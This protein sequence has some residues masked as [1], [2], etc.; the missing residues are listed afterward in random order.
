MR[1]GHARAS[2]A[3]S[4]DGKVSGNASVNYLAH[5]LLA[6]D[7]PTA[8]VGQILADCVSASSIATFEAEIQAGIRAHQKI[9]VYSDT[10][11]VFGA[12][13]QRLQPPYRRFA[14]VLLDVYFDHFLAK[15]WSRHGDGTALAEFAEQRYEILRRYRDLP[16]RRFRLV[17]DAMIRDNWLV[18]YSRL[19]GVERALRGISR[20]FKRENPIASGTTVL[21]EN[22]APLRSDFE[23]FFPQLKDYALTLS[24]S[25]S[26]NPPG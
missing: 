5:L 4:W 7:K 9:D 6:G 15:G 10:H 11:P 23:K 25:T 14:G 24:L 20:R 21:L 19:D 8:Q 17:V 16:S 22:Y 12:A 26:R 3:A 1:S 2:V 13:R 18:G